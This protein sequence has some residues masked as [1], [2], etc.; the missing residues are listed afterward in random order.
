MLINSSQNNL[1]KHIITDIAH[2]F[3][4][5]QRDRLNSVDAPCRQC[6]S[7]VGERPFLSA[8]VVRNPPI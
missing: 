5:L 8:V 2:R 4:Q 6:L 7:R 3:G 1:L